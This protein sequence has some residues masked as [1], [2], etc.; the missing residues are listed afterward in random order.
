[1]SKEIRSRPTK[2]SRIFLASVTPSRAGGV[3]LLA[4]KSELISWLNL[5]GIGSHTTYLGSLLP[6]YVLPTST[7]RSAID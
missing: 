2:K 1:M 5:I 6:P 7:V 3:R 4:A